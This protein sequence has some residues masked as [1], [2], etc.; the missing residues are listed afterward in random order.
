MSEVQFTASNP[1]QGLHPTTLV[2][3][4]RRRLLAVV[5]A[6]LCVSLVLLLG[7]SCELF[8]FRFS[9]E[10]SERIREAFFQAILADQQA[11]TLKEADGVTPT[12]TTLCCLGEIPDIGPR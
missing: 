11:G 7:T 8:A 10:Q 6:V 3:M 4:G 1:S 2:S 9:P 5:V 12:S